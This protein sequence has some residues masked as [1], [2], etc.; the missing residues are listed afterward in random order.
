MDEFYGDF[1]TNIFIYHIFREVNRCVDSLASF[2][3]TSQGYFWWKPLFHMIF[4][5]INLGFRNLDFVVGL[6]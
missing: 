1:K 3:I 4:V 5:E 6:V 2:G